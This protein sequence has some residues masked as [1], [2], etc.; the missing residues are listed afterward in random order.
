MK[1]SASTDSDGDSDCKLL[2]NFPA[3]L[4]GV[5]EHGMDMEAS[6]CKYDHVML[7]RKQEMYLKVKWRA[8]NNHYF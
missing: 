1:L 4:K 5:L 6:P 7:H 3:V 8:V 2:A